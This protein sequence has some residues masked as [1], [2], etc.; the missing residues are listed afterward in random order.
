MR[1]VERFVG[2]YSF[3]SNFYLWPIDYEDAIY[4]SVENAYQAAKVLDVS[5]RRKFE[6]CK[7]ADAKKM[8]RGVTL[9]PDWETLRLMVM[10][11]LLRKK[12]SDHSMRRKLLA[13]GEMELIE[14][15]WWRDSF[16]GQYQGVGENHLGKLLMKIREDLSLTRVAVSE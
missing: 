11:E 7:P 5:E 15:N 12:F 4:D 6:H 2:E 3:L 13:T 14:G 16:W 8:G 1:K 9:R 10:E